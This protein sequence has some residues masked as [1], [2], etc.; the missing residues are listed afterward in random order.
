MPNN[1][2]ADRLENFLNRKIED[3]GFN[4]TETAQ[5]L[6]KNMLKA[7][8]WYITGCEVPFAGKVADK[9][10]EQFGNYAGFFD[11]EGC[12][13]EGNEA[14]IYEIRR[15]TNLRT[16]AAGGVLAL[17]SWAGLIFD[18]VGLVDGMIRASLRIGAVYAKRYGFEADDLQPEDFLEIIA[19]WVGEKGA[20]DSPEAKYAF[21]TY[22]LGESEAN[23]L[24]GKTY[25]KAMT[26]SGG[27]ATLKGIGKMGVKS[28]GEVIKYFT[29]T[30]AFKIGAKQATKVVGKFTTKSSA[31]A[32]AKGA[33]TAP[34]LSWFGGCAVNAAINRWFMGQLLD[35]AEEYYD[36]KF[37]GLKALQDSNN[38]NT[39]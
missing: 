26:K 15:K 16:T 25:L 6:S 1:N 24:I 35:A 4:D 8:A 9:I 36:D 22:I 34:V 28:S 11:M 17:G 2:W 21:Y 5:W 30:Q 13:K 33:S 39:K 12:F 32:G 20:L 10:V 19:Y 18:L 27:K 31:K 37:R 29:T 14:G 23:K 38:N 7:I 3:T